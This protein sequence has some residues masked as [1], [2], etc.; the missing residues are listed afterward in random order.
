MQVALVV[1]SR[2]H[3]SGILSL[4]GVDTLEALVKDPGHGAGLVIQIR[5]PGGGE[6]LLEHRTPRGSGWR[7]ARDMAAQLLAKLALDSLRSN[8]DRD[9]HAP[10]G[11][12]GDLHQQ[13]QEIADG[14]M[15]PV[16]NVT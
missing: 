9:T 8:P 2:S 12:N 14:S 3:S 7:S 1:R 16:A 13:L 11:S 10:A 6:M 15:P 4:T 5:A